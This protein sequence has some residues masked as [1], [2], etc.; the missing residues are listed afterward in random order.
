MRRLQ[1]VRF[2]VVL[3]D[4]HETHAD[5]DEDVDDSFHEEPIDMLR[6]TLTL[7]KRNQRVL[8]PVFMRFKY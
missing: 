2:E 5:V 8:C 3:V 6:L 1:Q 7:D 4:R